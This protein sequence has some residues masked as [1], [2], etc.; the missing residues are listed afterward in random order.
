MPKRTVYGTKIYGEIKGFK[1]YIEYAKEEDIRARLEENDHYFYDVLP[2]A[3][4][5]GLDDKWMEKFEKLSIEIHDFNGINAFT[6][7]YLFN[8]MSRVS[9]KS[10]ISIPS[11]SSSGGGGSFGGGGGFSGGGFGG[12]GGGSW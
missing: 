6:Y 4:I 8:T 3:Y 2:Y 10:L 11:S 1:N 7:Y 9:A 5:F 12:G